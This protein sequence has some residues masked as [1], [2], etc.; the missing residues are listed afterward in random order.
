MTAFSILIFLN[1]IVV[2]SNRLV[3]MTDPNFEVP[4]HLLEYSEDEL[5][6]FLSRNGDNSSGVHEVILD[7]AIR[8]FRR[9]MGDPNVKWALEDDADSRLRSVRGHKRGSERDNESVRSEN[10]SV[11]SAGILRDLDPENVINKIYQSETFRLKVLSSLQNTPVQFQTFFMNQSPVKNNTSIPETVGSDAQPPDAVTKAELFHTVRE[12]N[13][14]TRVE[15]LDS[16]KRETKHI[17]TELYDA[18]H[19]MGELILSRIS[20]VGSSS[21]ATRQERDSEQPIS[22]HRDSQRTSN[23]PDGMDES[24]HQPV[25]SAVESPEFT[26]D[27]HLDGV[28]N[29]TTLDEA[30]RHTYIRRD[31]GKV[32]HLLIKNLKDGRSWSPAGT[33]KIIR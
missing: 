1:N 3:K 20:E 21:A 30:N 29:Q 32:P 23:N 24:C 12:I 16:I 11:S 14:N 9:F 4:A 13:G 26:S 31:L 5:R 22:A 2:S 10:I 17:K 8:A 6:D 33:P 19:K 25:K 27:P 15:L 7:R 18:I 28:T